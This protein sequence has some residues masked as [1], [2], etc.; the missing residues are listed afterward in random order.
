MQL[1]KVGGR[2]KALVRLDAVSKLRDVGDRLEYV[3]ARYDRLV[4]EVADG[5]VPVPDLSGRVDLINSQL[6]YVA[7]RLQELMVLE[8]ETSR[9]EALAAGEA[10]VARRTAFPRRMV[11]ATA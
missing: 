9:A 5:T 6:V 4:R 3:T 2:R 8:H 7:Q 10:D 11:R 1:V